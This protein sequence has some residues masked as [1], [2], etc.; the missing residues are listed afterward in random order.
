[1]K[2]GF[3]FCSLLFTLITGA[4][5]VKTAIIKVDTSI[6]TE[7]FTIPYSEIKII[8]ARF[9]RTKIGCCYNST[10][11]NRISAEKYDAKFPDS[12]HTYFSK[13]LNTFIKSDPQGKDQ[14]IVLIKQFRI[15][16]HFLRGIE[17]DPVEIEFTLKI[18]ASFYALHEN[19]CFKLF[20]VDNILLHN[21]EKTHERKRRFEEGS[22]SFALQALLH[23]LLQSQN[24]QVNS[25]QSSFTLSDVESA[26]QKRFD[27][28]VYT[29]PLRKGIYKSFSDF[30]NNTP[31]VE[32]FSIV[33]SQG[34]IN[35][36]E[37]KNGKPYEIAELWGVCDGTKNYMRIRDEFGEL[38]PNDKSFRVFSY[39]TISEIA[40]SAG[41]YDLMSGTFG[42]LKAGIKVRQYFDL[43]ME[44][45]RLYLQE[46]FGKSSI[47]L[48]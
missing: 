31:S 35:R 13:F 24:W 39:A 17:A 2:T 29:S 10:F 14:L 34:R 20:S 3:L 25:L 7:T 38:I 43:D 44:T 5:N 22:R 15:A 48:Q 36:L 23:K 42:K 45:G 16:D 9:D 1:M 30:K 11:L 18:S 40:G 6:N 21:I 37:D 12:F 19:K 28:P 46:I 47:S 41:G 4:Q 32:D 8:D 26:I 33:Y 27:L